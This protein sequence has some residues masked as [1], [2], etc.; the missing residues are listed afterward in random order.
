MRRARSPDKQGWREWLER[1][2][3]KIAG[4]PSID[5]LLRNALFNL[6]DPA[7]QL[8]PLELEIE[9]AV[10]ELDQDAIA[11]ELLARSFCAGEELASARCVQARLDHMS[12]MLV[13]LLVHLRRQ[14]PGYPFEY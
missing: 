12:A 5:E 13:N 8:A 2:E 14:R 3:E 9:R 1:V 7:T 6:D 4:E 11:A 10:M